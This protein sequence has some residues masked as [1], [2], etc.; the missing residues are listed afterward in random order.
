MKRKTFKKWIM[1]VC[2]FSRN[3]SEYI[4]RMIAK[5]KKSY[6][7]VYAENVSDPWLNNILVSI[8]QEETK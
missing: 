3:D 6:A 5:H 1:G 7:L 2:G 8:L 4:C